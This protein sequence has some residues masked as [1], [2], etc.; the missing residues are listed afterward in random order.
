MMSSIYCYKMRS[1]REIKNLFMKSSED[2]HWKPPLF[3]AKSQK[4]PN[5][6]VGFRFD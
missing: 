3:N 1:T 4:K 6:V 5:T 2:L